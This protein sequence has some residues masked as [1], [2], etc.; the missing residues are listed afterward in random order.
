M[1]NAQDVLDAARDAY[2]QALD[3]SAIDARAEVD[4]ALCA[5]WAA[6][7]AYHN[8]L[9]ADEALDRARDDYNN[10]L[11]AA[12]LAAAAARAEVANK[13]N[14]ETPSKPGEKI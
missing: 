11:D 8:E 9:D 1:T 3:N 13:S 6:R 12:N 14:Y 4:R 10:A 5:L 2:Y 7:D